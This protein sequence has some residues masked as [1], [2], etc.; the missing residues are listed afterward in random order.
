V[1]KAIS[2][3]A[4]GVYV[5][6]LQVVKI[7]YSANFINIHLKT[8]AHLRGFIYIQY[9][10]LH[11]YLLFNAILTILYNNTQIHLIYNLL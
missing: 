8:A 4:V 1:P 2:L 6:K 11:K 10:F 9:L 5:D 3:K 7:D